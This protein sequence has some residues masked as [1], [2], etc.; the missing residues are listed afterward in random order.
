MPLFAMMGFDHPESITRREEFRAEHRAYVRANIAPLKLAGA[1]DDADG[2]QIG[3][4]LVFE[5][6][7]EA[8][9]WA[10]IEAEPFYRAGIYKEVRVRLWNLVIGQIAG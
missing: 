5:A 1:F 4:L 10:W 7:D 6:P 8:A 2:R 9:V 3:S